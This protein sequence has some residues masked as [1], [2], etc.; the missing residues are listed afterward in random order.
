MLFL[1]VRI[2]SNY[3]YND[4]LSFI[5]SQV[6]RIAH[7]M[8]MFMMACS[9]LKAQ[10]SL[11]IQSTYPLSGIAT[12]KFDGISSGQ[13]RSTRMSTVTHSHLIH[14]G[15]YQSHMGKANLTL[16]HTLD[17]DEGACALPVSWNFAM[18][19]LRFL[20]ICPGR[21]LANSS[22]W[23]AVASILATMHISKAL[24][25][26]GKEIIPEEKFTSGITRYVSLTLV[27][28]FFSSGLHELPAILS[29][30][31]APYDLVT[32]LHKP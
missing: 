27:F 26:N 13:C 18:F 24:D 6:Y 22:L 17:L 4:S 32:R 1:L 10:L 14:L 28:Q 7:S 8:M 21:Y 12:R 9:S 20:R 25:K 5:L 23:I 2:W 16:R 3:T 15:I 30:L 11:Q 19:R 29:H 31:S